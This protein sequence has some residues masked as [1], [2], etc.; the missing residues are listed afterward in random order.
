MLGRSEVLH[1]SGSRRPS[2]PDRNLWFIV[3]EPIAAV[4]FRRKQ[5]SQ[6]TRLSVTDRECLTR[7]SLVGHQLRVPAVIQLS[8]LK[9]RQKNPPYFTDSLINICTIE[10]AVCLNLGNQ[11]EQNRCGPS[12]VGGDE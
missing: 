11:A 6:A 3:T 9:T 12:D 8:N 2:T 5:R 10:A 4:P 7:Y 1:T